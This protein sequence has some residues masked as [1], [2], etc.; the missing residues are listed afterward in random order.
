MNEAALVKLQALSAAKT[1]PHAWLFVGE[2]SQTKEFA[3]N[4]ISWLLCNNKQHA[5]ACGTCKACN[6]LAANTHP[7]FFSLT[8]PAEKNIY[9]N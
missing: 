3:D 4:F 6:L 9:A 5:H 8:P 1:L 2:Q 7:D